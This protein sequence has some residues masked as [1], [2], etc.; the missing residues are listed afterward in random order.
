M[1][2]SLVVT[3]SLLTGRVTQFGCVSLSGGSTGAPHS[4]RADLLAQ[5][6]DPVALFDADQTLE[7]ARAE[8]VH[9]ACLGREDEALDVVQVKAAETHM[10][11][12]RGRSRRLAVGGLDPP[13]RAGTRD[14]AD[15]GAGRS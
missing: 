5:D 12:N 6:Q 2:A 10:V 1:S 15:P 4:K 9:L 14:D 11:Q 8:Q 7:K 3:S 13:F